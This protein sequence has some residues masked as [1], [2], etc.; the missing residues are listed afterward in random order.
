MVMCM[1]LLPILWL[2]RGPPRPHPLPQ[3]QL[4]LSPPRLPCPSTEHPGSHSLSL[5]T[6][7]FNW[8]CPLSPASPGKEGGS[9]EDRGG[10]TEERTEAS[11]GGGSR[12]RGSSWL[13]TQ[14]S[15]K[16]QNQKQIFRPMSA[17]LYYEM[18]KKALVSK[19]EG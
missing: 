12:E 14:S 15:S 13:R 11:D 3:L 19:K 6:S 17:T 4:L 18:G 10:G 1:R 7:Y 16:T 5:T 2:L 8:I 9:A